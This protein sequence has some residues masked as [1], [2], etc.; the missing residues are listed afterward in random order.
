MCR[1]VTIP[2]VSDRCRRDILSSARSA[3]WTGPDPPS[4]PVWDGRVG[5]RARSGTMDCV[6]PPRGKAIFFAPQIWSAAVPK[7]ARRS[8][9]KDDNTIELRNWTENLHAALLTQRVIARLLYER[10][11]TSGRGALWAS[12]ILRVPRRE[13]S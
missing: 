2:A 13:P 7:A 6:P 4:L 5:C 10:H 11:P 1:Q 3:T 12:R 9:A 8:G